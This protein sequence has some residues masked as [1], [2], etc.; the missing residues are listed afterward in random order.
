MT[1]VYR[2][3]MT[4]FTLLIR[5][6][7]CSKYDQRFHCFMSRTND[8]RSSSY[9]SHSFNF[10]TPFAEIQRLLFLR[11][12][13][14]GSQPFRSPLSSRP[15]PLCSRWL[16][17]DRVTSHGLIMSSQSVVFRACPMHYVCCWLSSLSRYVP[18]HGPNSPL[19]VATN[20]TLRRTVITVARGIFGR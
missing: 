15:R 1:S 13:G 2:R 6:C 18:K 3:S 7:Q 16:W 9:R 14:W 8:R 5:L 19:D 20:F 4:S 11:A 10:L 17:T 12:L